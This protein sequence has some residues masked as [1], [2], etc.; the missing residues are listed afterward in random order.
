MAENVIPSEIF[1]SSRKFVRRRRIIIIF[2]SCVVAGIGVVAFWPAE[3]EP[4]YNGKKLSEW[5]EIYQSGRL[6]TL[7]LNE[8]RA[9]ASDAI[10]QIGTNALPWLM[11]WI[12]CEVRETPKW[13]TSLF[14]LACKLHLKGTHVEIAPNGKT[15]GYWA[16]KSPVASLINNRE[17]NLADYTERFGFKLLGAQ[18][19]DALP[20][21]E[22]LTRGT[23]SALSRR[24][25]FA[26][27]SVPDLVPQWLEMLTN[28]APS[29][30]CRGIRAFSSFD[31]LA[32][33]FP[34]LNISVVVP[35]LVER[36]DDPALRVRQA[37]T[38]ALRKIAPKSLTTGAKDF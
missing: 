29:L 17:R 3:R 21:L 35:P 4:E 9:E 33:A 24:A 27:M 16:E 12:Q 1:T 7:G 23:N 36:L 8:S 26:F 10:N 38:N 32:H 6:G 14:V 13:K 37:A 25:E 34:A 19:T 11:R 15:T 31:S 22:R 5:L 18:A 20:E 30:R 2:A 28:R